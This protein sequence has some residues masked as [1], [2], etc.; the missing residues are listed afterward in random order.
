MQR[1]RHGS[2][3]TRKLQR[4]YRTLSWG[5]GRRCD[6]RGLS[7]HAKENQC[8]RRGET[9]QLQGLHAQGNQRSSIDRGES[10][11]QVV[12]PMKPQVYRYPPA[13]WP[14]DRHALAAMNRT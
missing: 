8:S 7:T 9:V 4:L 1:Q 11:E 13:C 2:E 14:D 12:S 10:D 3:S 5:Q 6:L